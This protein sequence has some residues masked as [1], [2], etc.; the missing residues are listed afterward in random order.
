MK[1]G[2]KLVC[3]FDVDATLHFGLDE[4]HDYTNIKNS[5]NSTGA[6]TVLITSRLDNLYGVF[7]FYVKQ[8][9]LDIFVLGMVKLSFAIKNNEKILK[10]AD[11]ISKPLY[12]NYYKNIFEF[13]GLKLQ[14]IEKQTNQRMAL[15]SNNWNDEIKLFLK[16]L[17]IFQI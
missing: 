1:L 4:K 9:N 12:K 15:E 10:K 11:D 14:P 5:I 3:F 17:K 2:S 7:Q 13:K 16:K 8:C 6:I